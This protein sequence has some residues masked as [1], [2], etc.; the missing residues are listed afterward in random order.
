MPILTLSTD[1]G[2]QDFLVGAIKGQMLSLN[3]DFTIADI[4]HYLPQENFPHAAYICANA[5]QY[6][7]PQTFHLIIINLFEITPK[8]L[9]IAKHKHQYIACPDNGII[10]MITGTVPAEMIAIPVHDAANL[11]EFT[12]IILNAI[13]QLSEGATLQDIGK[14]VKT[15][16]EKAPLRPTFGDNWMEGHILFIDNFE[17]VVVNITKEEFELQRQNRSFKIAFTR[18]EEIDTIS[19]NYSS[20]SNGDKLAWF[21]SAGYLELAI[22]KGNMAGLFGLQGFN[23]KMHEGSV[24]KNKWFYQTVKILFGS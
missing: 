2:Q 6:F 21:N 9:L 5:F 20:V 3:P 4:T 10:T 12:Q 19:E 11:L 17:N 22:N 7:P 18:Y 16:N 24:N 23:Q 8:Q 15:I 13:H 14:P 1:T